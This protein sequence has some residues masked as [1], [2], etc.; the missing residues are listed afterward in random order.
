M[1]NETHVLTGPQGSDKLFAPMTHVFIPISFSA[2]VL[3]TQLTEFA[4]DSDAEVMKLY[5][6]E[7][8]KAKRDND[9]EVLNFCYGRIIEWYNLRENDL[10]V[11]PINF[12][13]N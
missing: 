12:S 1:Q 2:V 4:L 13:K 8:L 7:I 9:K 11:I 6:N 5:H 10:G 3:E